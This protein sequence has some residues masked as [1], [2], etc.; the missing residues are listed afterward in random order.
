MKKTHKIYKTNS[1]R[2]TEYFNHKNK[3]NSD[4]TTK[5]FSIL[6]HP[7]TLE[8]YE[9][10]SPGITEK[11][12]S[13]IIREQEFRHKIESLKMKGLQSMYRFGQFLSF[14]LAIVIIFVTLF[15]YSKYENQ[16]LASV[17]FLSGFGFL[18]IINVVSFNKI[19]QTKHLHEDK[20]KNQKS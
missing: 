13:I 15:V 5:N 4:Q 14:I 1:D 6:P 16:L 18:T 20:H 10:I 17:I 19:T 9:A 12:G 7:A 8:S 3:I 11:L 2:N